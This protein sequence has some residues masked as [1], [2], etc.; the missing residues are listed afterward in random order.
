MD[1]AFKQTLKAKAHHLKP[2]IL[3]GS[4]GLTPAVIEETHAALLAH[5]LIKVKIN[6]AEKEDRQAMAIELCEQLQAELV[7][8]IGN[9]AI[10][11]RK[12]DEK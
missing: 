9:T 12:N 8:L 4:K 6:G 3:I 10:I 2:V 1:T 5:E 11:Y 7:Q